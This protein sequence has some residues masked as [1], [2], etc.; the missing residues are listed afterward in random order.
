MIKIDRLA[1]TDLNLLLS[2]YILLE[3]RNVTRASER[4]HITQPAASRT[5]TRLRELFDDALLTRSGNDMLLTPKAQQ[6]KLQL[7]Q[8]LGSLEALVSPLVFDPGTLEQTFTVAIPEVFGQ[9]IIA[10]LF[11]ALR[12]EAPGVTLVFRDPDEHAM[13]D[14]VSGELDFLFTRKSPETLPASILRQPLQEVNG[15]ILA[16]EDHPLAKRRKISVQQLMEQD[17]IDCYP[18]N[19]HA[20][21]SPLDDALSE[22]N[23]QRRVVFRCTHMLSALQAVS[24]S[25]CLLLLA[26]AAENLASLPFGLTELPVPAEIQRHRVELELLQHRSTQ[27]S[28]PHNWLKNRLLEHLN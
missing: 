10:P 24:G 16:S 25:N 20:R 15:M 3:E 22:E 28:E 14:L 27:S 17:W 12:R 1:R 13:R 11:N 26:N 8:V 5:L 23:L 9:A 19:R 4:L 21:P 6:L 18:Q 7:P 2:L